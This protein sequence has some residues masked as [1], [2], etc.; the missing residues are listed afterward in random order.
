M[1]KRDLHEQNRRSW[2]EATRQ[3]NAHKGDQASFLRDGGSTLFP[4]EVSLLADIQGKTLLHLQCN[5]GQDTLSIASRL[6]AVVTGVDISDEAIDFARNL[7][8][9]S[10]I[11]GTFIRSDVFDWFEQNTQQF[12]LVFTSYGATGWLSDL[13]A[14]G[15]GIFKALKPGGRFVMIEFH[16]AMLMFETDWTLTYDYMGGKLFDSEGVGD[17]VGESGGGLTNTGEAI[18]TSEPYKNPERAHEF[19]WGLADHVS[20]LLEA[21][22]RLKHLREYP[23]SNGWKPFPDLV[24]NPGR[25]MTLAEGKPVLPLMFSITAV[26]PER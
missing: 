13:S 15:R 9:A 20:A 21:G 14:W 19:A 3:H 5:A 10:G 6:G 23:Y 22:F 7:S 4:E 11:P 25:R 16:P 12:D 26:K 24:E 18:E 1:V 17:Y 2:N 8:A